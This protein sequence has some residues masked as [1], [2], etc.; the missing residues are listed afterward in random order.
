[1][2]VD[3]NPLKIAVQVRY[4]RQWYTIAAF[5]T[6]QSAAVNARKSSYMNPTADYRTV[7]IPSGRGLRRFKNGT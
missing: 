1:M 6:R 2:R 4:L 5:S 3:L 7:Y